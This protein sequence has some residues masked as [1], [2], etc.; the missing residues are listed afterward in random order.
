MLT[1][2]SGF[3]VVVSPLLAGC[4]QGIIDGNRIAVSPAFYELLKAAKTQRELIALLESLKC[5]NLNQPGHD[6]QWHADTA[7]ILMAKLGITG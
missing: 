7:Q 2:L 4:K 6:A 5:V 3:E 1:Q